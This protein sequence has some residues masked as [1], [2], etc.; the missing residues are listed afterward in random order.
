[1]KRILFLNSLLLSWSLVAQDNITIQ[2]ATYS[3]F[4]G[5]E[6][7]VFLVDVARVQKSDYMNHWEKYFKSLTELPVVRADNDITIKGATIKKIGSRVFSI[8]LHFQ[9][10]AIGTQMYVG[11]QDT[12]TGFIGPD[13]P[14]YG[15]ELKKLILEETEKVYVQTRGEDVNK[16]EA[17]LKTLEKDL[18]SIRDDQAKLQKGIMQDKQEIDQLKNEIVINEG[19]MKELM[20]EISDKR[21]TVMALSSDA[22]KEV[23]KKAEKDAKNMEK[24]RDRVRKK[25]DK[26]KQKIFDLEKEIQDKQYDLDKLEPAEDEANRKVEAQRNLLIE[27]QQDVIQMKR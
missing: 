19:V 23:R 7:S 6:A 4:T 12:V 18:A 13:D 11:F 3:G 17:Y 2:A 9:P 20:I 24:K 15:I 8:Y 22:P 14:Q 21:S 5:T 26:D 16:E 1:M 10:S 27:I 25:I